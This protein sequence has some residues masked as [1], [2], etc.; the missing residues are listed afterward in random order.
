MSLFSRNSILKP[1]M[2]RISLSTSFVATHFEKNTH[3]ENNFPSALIFLPFQF[4]QLGIEFYLFVS[5]GGVKRQRV[6]V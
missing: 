6:H 5:H 3:F 4:F 2:C 1:K